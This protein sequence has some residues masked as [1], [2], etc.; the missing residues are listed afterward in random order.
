VKK[1]QRVL[2]VVP[3]LVAGGSEGVLRMIADNLDRER[4]EVHLG[5]LSKVK[6]SEGAAV[7]AHVIVHELGLRHARYAGLGLLRLIWGLRP[8]V[9]LAAGGP[10]GVVATFAATFAPRGTRVV[11]R[12]GTMPGCSAGRQTRWERQAFAWSQ[13]HADRVICQSKAMAS[14]VVRTSRVKP[15]KLH[16]VYNPVVRAQANVFATTSRF[17]A[18][19]LLAVGRLSPE[20]RLDLVIRAFAIVKREY[21]ASASLVIL[22]DGPCRRALEDLV[23]SEA[24]DESVPFEGYLPNPR[25]WMHDSIALVMASEFE[26]LPNVVLEAISIGLPVVAIDCPG[27]IREIAETA[28]NIA[29]I[30][31]ETPGALAL[32]MAQTIAS[33][34][35]RTL[36]NAAFRERF[37]LESVIKRY[38]QILSQ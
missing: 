22:G 4:F 30:E 8:R 12:Q 25:T 7:A 38:E 16:V 32:A 17:A 28:P 29:L 1:T 36:P 14:D 18:P 3:R 6:P 37:S 13:R 31:E 9:V 33:P 26:G 35:Q 5:V 10:T 15:E 2:I 11:V 23:I 21:C 27:G 20:K 19:T 24:V 34:P